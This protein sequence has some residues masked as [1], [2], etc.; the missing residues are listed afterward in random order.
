[1]IERHRSGYVLYQDED[2]EETQE[3]DD[4]KSE[5]ESE[6]ET[7]AEDG[8]EGELEVSKTPPPSFF[9]FTSNTGDSRHQ[10]PFGLQVRGRFYQPHSAITEVSERSADSSIAGEQEQGFYRPYTPSSSSESSS[11]RKFSNGSASQASHGSGN[12][13]SDS[14]SG[15][16]STPPNKDFVKTSSLEPGDVSDDERPDA[17]AISPKTFLKLADGTATRNRFFR[18]GGPA[19]VEVP[20]VSKPFLFRVLLFTCVAHTNR[21]N[22][23]RT[24][25]VPDLKLPKSR[26]CPLSLLLLPSTLTKRNTTHTTAAK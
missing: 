7:E 16:L 12:S 19:K 9:S 26:R 15:D 5:F 13:N 2:E 1:M 3:E 4:G 17:S 24:W 18:V 11:S 8:K 23:D 22:V 6:F 25:D 10:F 20:T 21:V 14:S